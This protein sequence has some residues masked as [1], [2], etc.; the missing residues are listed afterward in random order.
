LVDSLRND[1][2]AGGVEAAAMT[3]VFRDRPRAARRSRKL[4]VRLETGDALVHWRLA[5]RSPDDKVLF[6]GSFV[7]P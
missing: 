5:R 3:T 4:V 6:D 7:G 2:D 1:N